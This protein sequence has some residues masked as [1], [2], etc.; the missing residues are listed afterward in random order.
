[1]DQIIAISDLLNLNARESH[2]YLDLVACWDNQRMESHN[3]P[4]K[5]L[6]WLLA[7]ILVK[8]KALIES[9]KDGKEVA[10][11]EFLDEL[12][13]IDADDL[14]KHFWYEPRIHLLKYLLQL[15]QGEEFSRDKLPSR[16]NEW[17]FDISYLESKTITGE[18]FSRVLQRVAAS[19]FV[20]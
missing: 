4:Q 6:E 5:L 8:N 2:R 18:S 7:A 10:K 19:L 17:P 9:L 15:N 16:Q 12:N 1:M 14:R 13:K 11:E 20:V 3:M